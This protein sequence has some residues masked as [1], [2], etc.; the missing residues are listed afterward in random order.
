M[1]GGQ[2]APSPSPPLGLPFASG[3]EDCLPTP[4]VGRPTVQPA[5]ATHP[6]GPSDHG[7]SAAGGGRPPRSDRQAGAG[8]APLGGITQGGRT[9]RLHAGPRQHLLSLDPRQ[10][11]RGGPTWARCLR[12]GGPRPRGPRG[13]Q[14]RGAPCG[15]GRRPPPPRRCSVW[16]SSGPAPPTGPASQEAPPIRTAC[17][18]QGAPRP[19]GGHPVSPVGTP[20]PGWQAP[21]P[22]ERPHHL[23]QAATPLGSLPFPV[24]DPPRCSG[25]PQLLA[26]TPLIPVRSGRGAR[27]LPGALGPGHSACPL[28]ALASRGS[29]C[30]GP[31][32][33]QAAPPAQ[34]AG[35]APSQRAAWVA[36]GEQAQEGK[37]QEQGQLPAL[38]LTT[39]E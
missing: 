36:A 6:T 34:R 8:L 26:H 5:P 35:C 14:A 7:A 24:R 16:R 33:G 11:A 12:A 18:P 4:N 9:G 15:S 3:H 38:T 28:P 17:P 29:G 23:G 22:W 30:R 10:Q 13:R 20:W 1:G 32:R 25:H 27:G 21:C 19:H 37:G 39:A 2:P 31:R